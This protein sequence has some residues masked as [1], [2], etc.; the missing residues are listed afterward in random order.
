MNIQ[1][2]ID[3]KGKATGL[4]V[5]GLGKGVV[6]PPLKFRKKIVQTKGA[7]EFAAMKE[8]EHLLEEACDDIHK[9]PIVLD[10]IMLQ[11]PNNPFGLYVSREDKEKD[12]KA[13][14]A[15]QITSPVFCEKWKQVAL[16]TFNLQKLCAPQSCC[17]II[18]L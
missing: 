13:Q 11:E 12:P 4:P 14:P 6:G 17:W 18:V 1:G 10:T 8:Y 16:F 2:Y 15:T 5:I 7:G 3:S 9:D